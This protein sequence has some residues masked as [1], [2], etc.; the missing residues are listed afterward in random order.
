MAVVDRPIDVG[1]QV[2]VTEKPGWL[3]WL[4]TVDHKK[5]GIMYIVSALVFFVIGGIEA[6]LIRAQLAVPNNNFVS[7]DVY[8]QLF[9][10]HGTTM[11]FLA[12]MPLNVGLGNYIVPLMVGARDMAFPRLNALSIWLFIFGGLMLY[13][14]FMLGGAPAMGWFAYAPLTMR[15]YSPTNGVEFWILGLTLTGV[16]SIAGA[17]NFIVT[18]LNMRAPG[19]RLNRMPLF[20]WMTLV[21]SFILIFAFP[22]LTAAQVMLLFDRNYGTRFFDATQGGD[23]LLW[24]HLFWFFGHPEVYILILPAFG[25]IS[26]ITSTFSR[27]PLFGY[28]FLAYSGIAI[29]FLGFVVWAHHMFAT[30]LGPLADAFFSGASML[31]AVPTGV[32]IFNWIGTLYGGSLNLKTPLYFAIGFIAMF[33]VGGISG[34]TLASPPLDLQQTD[35]YYVV[36]HFH[37]VLFGGSM[38]GIFA[39]IYYWFP[40]MTGRMYNERLGKIHFWLTLISFNVTFGPMHELGNQGMPR[41]IWT[42][43]AGMGWDL[44]NMVETVGSFLLA[45]GMLIFFWNLVVSYRAGEPAGNDPWDGSTL[46]WATPSPP[47]AYNFARIPTVH[48]RRPLWDVKYPELEVAHVPGS[49]P[50]KRSDRAADAPTSPQQTQQGPIHIHL[51]SPTYAPLVVAFGL[52]VVFY[53]VIYTFVLSIIGLI[54][55]ALGIFGWFLRSSLDSAPHGGHAGH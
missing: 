25:I 13:S 45:F 26:E 31:I 12:I 24:Q 21:T 38:L 5:I 2:P 15:Q 32:K 53:G 50:P 1:V 34:I 49:N 44:W 35:S 29:G 48:S 17:I 51:P 43:E 22:A 10:M 3:S 40:K 42:Y 27:K 52:T 47:P 16:A 23:P 28:A 9:T 7:P 11:V 37:Y 18:I 8:N 41:R 4:S 54:I 36:A 39:G 33:I 6:L 30:G 14:S 46:E 20:A 19:M 55:A